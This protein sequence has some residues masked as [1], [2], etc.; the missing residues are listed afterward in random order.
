MSS[1]SRPLVWCLLLGAASLAALVSAGCVEESTEQSFDWSPPYRASSHGD[2]EL[3]A[4]VNPRL[5]KR[6]SPLPSTFRKTGVRLDPQIVDLGRELFH[7]KQL[8]SDG[9]TSCASCHDLQKGG[10]DGERTSRG[11][12]QQL[13]GRNSPSVLNAAG[14]FRQ[15]WDGRAATIEE[16]AGGPIL[17]PLEMGMENGEA[18]ERVLRAD[19]SYRERF[20]RAFPGEREPVTFRNVTTAIGAF[21]RTLST[22]GRWDAFLEGDP[23]ALSERELAGLKSFLGLGCMVCH[24]GTMVGGATYERVGVVEPWP[25]QADLGRFEISKQDADRMVFKVPSLRNVTRTAPYFHD[26]SSPTLED[27]I[28]RMGRHQLGLDLEAEEVE[29]IAAWLGTLSGEANGSVPVVEQPPAAPA[30]SAAAEPV[31]SA[32]PKRD[33]TLRGFMRGTVTSAVA[34]EDFGRIERAFQG[35]ASMAPPG[36][37]AWGGFAAEGVAAAKAKDLDRVRGACGSCHSAYRE[38]VSRGE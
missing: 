27:A 12:R 28:R 18:V 34:S 19:A 7:E 21:E 2:D 38:Q 3:D 9:S 16:Q 20:A 13:G 5:L 31:A 15:F 26:G 8:S 14:Q 35:I 6:F 33:L 36:L 1:P 24:T 4:R 32:A 10:A 30:P 37:P 22:P 29:S 17:N 11:V 23:E 25:N